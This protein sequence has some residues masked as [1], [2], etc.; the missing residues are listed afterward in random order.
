MVPFVAIA[1]FFGRF[2]NFFN[3]ESYGY[4]TKSFL[5]MGIGSGIDYTEVH[6]MFLYEAI[7]NLAIFIFLRIMQKRRKFKGQI[8]LLYCMC[9]S[10]FRAILEGFRVDSL[11]FY[12]FRASQVL[13]IIIFVTSVVLYIINSKKISKKEDVKAEVKEEAKEES[14][15]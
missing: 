6:P 3:V 7:V 10:G 5:R 11:M 9:Y 14:K 15:D 8:L 13:S 12:N 1:Q 4:E 2:G